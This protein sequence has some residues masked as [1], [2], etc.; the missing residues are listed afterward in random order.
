VAAFGVIETMPAR[1]LV[2]FMFIA[3]AVTLFVWGEPLISALI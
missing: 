3:G 1:G 2:I